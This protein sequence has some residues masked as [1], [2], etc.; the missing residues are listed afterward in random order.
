[1]HIW[2]RRSVS[3][4]DGTPVFYGR[5]GRFVAIYH[6]G[7]RKWASDAVDLLFSIV[8]TLAFH[9][10]LILFGSDISCSLVGIGGTLTF[11]RLLGLSGSNLSGSAS[12]FGG[13]TVGGVLFTADVLHPHG[14]ILMVTETILNRIGHRTADT[15]R[16]SPGTSMEKW[17][18]TAPML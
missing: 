4:I 16:S 8:G 18:M 12:A 10:K 3:V 6:A 14:N 15:N 17:A 5:F 7:H 1:M 2:F 11:H 9:C 13:C